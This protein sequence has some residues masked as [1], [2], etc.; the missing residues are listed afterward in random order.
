MEIYALRL[1]WPI[2]EACP[3]DPGLISL[4]CL[5]QHLAVGQAD[6]IWFE[7]KDKLHPGPRGYLIYHRPSG[8]IVHERTVES[9]E[10]ADQN[11]VRRRPPRRLSWLRAWSR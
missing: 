2:G 3:S 7:L 11:P 5:E 6:K 1:Y 9:P 4:S 10:F 8:K